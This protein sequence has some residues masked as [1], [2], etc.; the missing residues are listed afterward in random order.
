MMAR[1]FHEKSNAPSAKAA[2]VTV[3]CENCNKLFT[4]RGIS[5][6]QK[7][8]ISKVVGN[9]KKAEKTYRFCI[10]NEEIY[11]EFLSFLGNQ[12]LTKLQMATGDHYQQCEPELAEY[13][14]Q[15][16][17]DNPIA[18]RNLCRQCLLSKGYSEIVHPKTARRQYGFTGEHLQHCTGIV[19]AA[20]F[21]VKN[22]LAQRQIAKL[23]NRRKQTQ[24][25]RIA[26]E[27]VGQEFATFMKKTKLIN[28]DED[29]LNECRERYFTL[30]AKVKEHGL[31]FQPTAFSCKIYINDGIG[32]FEEVIQSVADTIS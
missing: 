6:H 18:K 7:T 32:S 19:Y 2:K 17:N 20:S 23:D 14:C 12:T 3:P 30:K 10:L 8:C 4:T 15:C 24:R 31:P 16:E 27:Q 22:G 13:C 29:D 26:Y 5:R 1:H 9:H 11:E 28:R 21:W 25:T